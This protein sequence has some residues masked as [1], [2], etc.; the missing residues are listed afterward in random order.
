MRCVVKVG[1]GWGGGDGQ[2]SHSG[3]SQKLDGDLDH[4]LL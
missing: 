4:P 1:A 3:D 2:E